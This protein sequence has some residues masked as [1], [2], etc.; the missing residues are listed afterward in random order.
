MPKDA[1]GV[2]SEIKKGFISKKLKEGLRGDGRKLDEFREIV[3]EPNYVPRAQ[4]SAFVKLGRTKVVVGVKIE[5]GEPFPD[6]PNLGV[7]TTNVE[8][9]PM[10]FPTFEPG[11]PNEESIE[12]ARVV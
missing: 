2:L 12:I 9:L 1:T 5:S 8:M 7:M 4:G 10:A 11:P 3:I 6:T